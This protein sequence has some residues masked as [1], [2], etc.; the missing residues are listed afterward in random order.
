MTDG[1]GVDS[2]CVETTDVVIVGSGVAGCVAAIGL[3]QRGASVVL[4][5]KD[6]LEDSNTR[7][8]QGG[9]AAVLGGSE[10]SVA[11]HL[12]DTLAAGGGH[13]D[14]AATELL[15]REA[16]AA[17]EGLLALGAVLDRTEDGSLA[18]SREGGHRFARVLHAGGAATGAELSR[19]L[20]AALGPA[21]VDCREQAAARELVIEAGR[22]RGVVADIGGRSTRFE[23]RAV[24]LATGGAG[25]L[26]AVTT[27][28]TGAT[29]DG[30]AMALRAGVPVADLEFVQFHPTALAAGPPGAPRLLL[31]EALRGEGALLLGPE[32]NRFVDELAPRDVVSRAVEAE[33]RAARS[34]HVFLDARPVDAFA[35]RFPAL[36]AALAAFDLDPARDLLPVA[37]AAH[38]LSGGI[39]TDLDGASALPGLWAVG[40][41]ACSGAQGANRLA[42]NSLLEGLVFASRAAQAISGGRVGP[43]ADGALA[44]LLE[45]R[46]AGALPVRLLPLDEVTG[47]DVVR[48]GPDD[49]SAARFR[50]Q[51]AASAGAGVVREP[52]GLAKA[53][54]EMAI[55]GAVADAARVGH[56]EVPRAVAEL[57]D[58]ALVGRA[59]VAAALARQESRG[60]HFRADHPAA[61]EAFR[62]R[63][64]FGSPLSEAAAIAAKTDAA[65]TYAARNGA[66]Q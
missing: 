37:P 24:V 57:G 52:V 44:P 4:L 11:A 38:F 6:R 2:E 54:A 19:V 28:P 35:E 7:W 47:T 48:A 59:L 62:L 58:L 34:P 66:A 43:R 10:D 29:G 14:P 51:R 22:C 31:S 26:F 16:A 65:R 42:S 20:V 17:V 39:L 56:G 1:R 60:G 9:V 61:S 32:G 27:N 30:I 63:F 23:A 15:V 49:V 25:Q 50:L 12:E 33:M 18:R 40:E 45:E 21:G 46:S 41:V 36:C 3:A 8:A 64:A 13:S 5:T 53:G 55:A